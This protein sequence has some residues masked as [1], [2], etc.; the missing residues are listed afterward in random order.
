M[1]SKEHQNYTYGMIHSSKEHIVLVS[2]AMT[3]T[4]IRSNEAEE[5]ISF[6][7]QVRG[8]H[9]EKS[10]GPSAGTRSKHYGRI[11]L[12]CLHTGTTCVAF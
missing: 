3:N 9:L 6:T 10:A 4:V 2:G 7:L 8:H 1:N 12:L 11:L 5:R